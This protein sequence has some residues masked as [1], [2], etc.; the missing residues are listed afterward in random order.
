VRTNLTIRNT[1]GDPKDHIVDIEKNRSE[2]PRLGEGGAL[3]LTLRYLG[4]QHC[5]A[6]QQLHVFLNAP[7]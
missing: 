5:S 3:M 4:L 7:G 6:N 1:H 2:A